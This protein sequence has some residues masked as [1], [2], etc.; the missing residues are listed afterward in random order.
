MSNVEDIYTHSLDMLAAAAGAVDKQVAVSA[1]RAIASDLE[2]SELR[3]VATVLA[4]EAVWSVRPRRSRRAM[5]EWIEQ[6]RFR[7][8]TRSFGGRDV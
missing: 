4:V 7:V 8:M 3:Q 6:K 5:Q 1:V 2:A